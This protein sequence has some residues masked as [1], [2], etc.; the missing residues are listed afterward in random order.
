M[1]LR[2]TDAVSGS[3]PHSVETQKSC[4]GPAYDAYTETSLYHVEPTLLM[5]ILQK[6]QHPP[7]LYPEYMPQKTSRRR[8]TCLGA[9]NPTAEGEEVQESFAP[10][11]F[12][13]SSFAIQLY[14]GSRSV[15]LQCTYKTKTGKQ[16]HEINFRNAVKWWIDMYHV[17]C[18][19]QLSA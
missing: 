6:S 17:S 4:C 11:S 8:T 10:K 14:S 12:S 1:H 13:G 18:I 7:R 3:R 15:R 5:D 2:E 9:C 16:R 19:K